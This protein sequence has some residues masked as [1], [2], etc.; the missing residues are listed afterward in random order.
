[1][2]EGRAGPLEGVPEAPDDG[3][4]RG[5]R[6]SSEDTALTYRRT[7]RSSHKPRPL[8]DGGIPLQGPNLTSVL[9]GEIGFLQ[10][11]RPYGSRLGHTD[12]PEAMP[13]RTMS[14]PGRS[15]GPRAK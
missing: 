3:R 12:S 11:L 9:P 7:D 6:P 4:R 13:Q 10:P 14:V 5:G 1:M 15:H 2:D 8:R